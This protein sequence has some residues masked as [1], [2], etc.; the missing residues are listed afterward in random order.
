MRRQLLRDNAV[1]RLKRSLR[2]HTVPAQKR[3]CAD[4]VHEA[5]GD[6]ANGRLQRAQRR[7]RVAAHGAQV[8]G[9]RHEVCGQRLRTGQGRTAQA[10]QP[11]L[12]G[13]TGMQVLMPCRRCTHVLAQVPAVG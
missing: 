12:P 2:D 3:G 4:D 5:N 9:T 13:V 8:R 7:L 11:L 1:V 10:G 6:G